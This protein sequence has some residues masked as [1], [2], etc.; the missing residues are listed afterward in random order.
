MIEKGQKRATRKRGLYTPPAKQ[1]R[2]IAASL[3]GK[4]N[5]EISRQEGIKRDTV[6]RILSRPDVQEL[7]AE[8]RQ[9]TRGLVPYCIDGLKAKLVTK[10]GKLRRRID[11][12][13]MVEILKG[14]Q[15]FVPK[16]EEELSEK[17]EFEGR[18]REE[19]K[20]FVDHQ[21]HWPEE[22]GAAGEGGSKTED[23]GPGRTLP[24]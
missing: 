8:Y 18:S 1:T 5:R 7:L 22:L 2:V 3:A 9:Q 20:F 21:G 24:D 6:A 11:W 23:P 16:Q 12:R 4:S 17:D 10:T 13:M 15:I 14:T 19:I